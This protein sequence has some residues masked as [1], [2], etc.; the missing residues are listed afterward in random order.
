MKDI[1][2]AI[3]K[4]KREIAYLTLCIALYFTITSLL[5]ITCLIKHFSGVSCPGCGMTR[6]VKALLTLNFSK[7]FY[8][9]PLVFLLIPIA[10]VLLVLTVKKMYK[11]RRV[12]VCA[13]A[14]LFV[15]VY[16]YRFIFTESPIL[17]F[18]PQNGFFA[19]LFLQL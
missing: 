2:C 3:I 17:V 16:L 9:H 11:T 18:E 14:V 1:F 6:A 13:A 4:K 8:Y 5:D 15:A 10:V 12:F 7:A 19:K